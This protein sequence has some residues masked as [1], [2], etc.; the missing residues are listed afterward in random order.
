MLVEFVLLSLV[1]II[2]DQSRVD[3][4]GSNI[5]FERNQHE[6]NY[7]AERPVGASNG[8][9]HIHNGECLFGTFYIFL[10]Q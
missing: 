7:N 2:L 10:H 5:V 3:L 8:P 1:Q 9:E 6:S 4:G